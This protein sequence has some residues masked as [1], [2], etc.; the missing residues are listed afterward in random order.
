[1]TPQRNEARTKE[2]LV[3]SVIAQIQKDLY[4]NELQPVFDMLLEID[5]RYLQG[6]LTEAEHQEH[7][8]YN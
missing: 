7:M 8:R 3:L 5:N 1:M 6:F 4:D 2:R